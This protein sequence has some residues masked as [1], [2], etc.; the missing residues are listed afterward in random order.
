MYRRDITDE[1]GSG[2][3]G[4]TGSIPE[5]RKRYRKTAADIS[6]PVRDSG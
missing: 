5:E 3:I 2:T 4:L 6:I 1:S